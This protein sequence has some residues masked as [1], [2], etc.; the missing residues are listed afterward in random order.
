MKRLTVVLG[1]TI[2][3]IAVSITVAQADEIVVV[4]LDHKPFR[5]V[6]TELVRVSGEG[7]AGSKIEIKIE[8]PA[9]VLAVHNIVY[10]KNGTNVIGTT[11]RDFYLQPT[12][13]RRLVKARIIVIP[14]DGGEPKVTH[15]EFEVQ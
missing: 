2:L 12:E 3:A 9:K 8:G 1:L 15:Y 6:E 5:V 7:I 4:P 13:R 11:V 14:P 10:R